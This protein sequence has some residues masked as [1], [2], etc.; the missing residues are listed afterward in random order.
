MKKRVQ[1]IGF[2]LL[3]ILVI[4]LTV[5]LGISIREQSDNPANWLWINSQVTSISYCDNVATVQ[6]ADGH[7]VPVK[8]YDAQKLLIG[9]T[10]NLGLRDGG[11]WYIFGHMAEVE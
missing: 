4:G 1:V 3:A 5:W 2:I 7:V 6:F 10:Y 11:G 8:M 9:H